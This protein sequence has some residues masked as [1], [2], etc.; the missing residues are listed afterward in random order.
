MNTGNRGTAPFVAVGRPLANLLD[1][2]RRRIDTCLLCDDIDGARETFEEL[3]S[4]LR[5]MHEVTGDGLRDESLSDAIHIEAQR[6]AVSAIQ[7]IQEGL[8]ADYPELRALAHAPAFAKG[9]NV[10]SDVS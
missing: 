9:L 7:M 3:R 10:C 2:K 4:V 1:R 6:A 8:E 5:S